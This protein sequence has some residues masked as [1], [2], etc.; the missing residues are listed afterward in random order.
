MNKE[1]LTYIDGIAEKEFIEHLI[2]KHDLNKGANNNAC[3]FSIL[4][5]EKIIQYGKDHKRTS[6]DAFA[7]YL[8]DSIPE[9]YEDEAHAFID[10]DLLTDAGKAA[11]EH[12]WSLQDSN[13]KYYYY[14]ECL[15]AIIGEH[16]YTAA[17]VNDLMTG[18]NYPMSE[19]DLIRTAAN[20]EATLY[21]YE[22]DTA[23]QYVNST[24]LY[25]CE[26]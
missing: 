2:V 13:A 14:F 19:K 15:D 23:G 17:E 20:Y 18:S 16:Y 5:L 11:K 25:E 21:R 10:D 7:N 22:K 3:I 6:K 24:C 8:F 26:V 1:Q 12:Y 9:L 4:M